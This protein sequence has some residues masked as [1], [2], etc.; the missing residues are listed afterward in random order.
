[1][2]QPLWTPNATRIQ[3]SNMQKFMNELRDDGIQVD[4]Y[5]DLHHWS[6]QHLDEFWKKTWDFGEKTLKIGKSTEPRPAQEDFSR[7]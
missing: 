2:Q 5:E 1:M 3:N 4:T 7:G 6:V